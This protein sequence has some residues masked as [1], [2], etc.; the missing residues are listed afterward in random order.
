MKRG[1]ICRLASTLAEFVG[2]ARS[3]VLIA[4]GTLVAVIGTVTPATAREIR[5]GDVVIRPLADLPQTASHGYHEF[6]FVV[7]NESPTESRRVTLS[8]PQSSE[9]DIG[10]PGLSRV[11]RTVTVGPGSTARLH[12]MQPPLPVFGNSLQVRIDGEV[13]SEII[14]WVTAHPRYWVGNPRHIPSRGPGS[15]DLL[16]SQGLDEDSFPAHSDEDYRV[17]RATVPISAWSENWLAYSGYDGLVTTVAELEQAPRAVVEALWRYVEAGG[18]LVCLG[19]VTDGSEWFRERRE[20]PR[21]S[22]LEQGVEVDYAGFGVVLNVAASTVA[23]LNSGQLDRLDAAWRRS[24]DPWD[25]ARDLGSVHGQFPVAAKLE[26]PVRGLFVV[27]LLFTLLIGPA[28][29]IFLSRRKRRIWLLWTVPGLSLMA[30]VAVVVWVLADEGLVRFQRSATI[31]VLDERVRRATSYGWAGYYATLTSGDGLR[32][33]LET[34]VSPILAWNYRGPKASRTVVWGEAQHLDQGWLR[35]RVPS[36][37]MLRKTEQRR[38]RLSLRWSSA[39]GPAGGLEVVNGLGVDLETLWV[40]G[41]TGRLYR[42]R[43]S[44]AAGIAAELERTD[45]TAAGDVDAVRRL[46]HGD[47]MGRLRRLEQEPA[48]FLRPG[49]YLA[50]TRSSPF[51]E[52]GLD[53]VDRAQQRTLIYGISQDRTLQELAP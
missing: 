52:D 29:L 53:R 12:L 46:Y 8:G 26:V 7:V 28:N 38:E 3:V 13:Q 11:G 14:P 43:E 32:F 24:R 47:L 31:T 18:A 17:S 25:R 30:C 5:Y 22:V 45:A 36:Y 21:A 51:V 15:R 34:E 41:P 9:V 33:G 50:V 42:A 16:I 49:T 35:A 23:E 40:A 37:F 2:K 27:V 19:E 44:L 10:L 1:S 6:S 48:Q 39:E 4:V 20:R